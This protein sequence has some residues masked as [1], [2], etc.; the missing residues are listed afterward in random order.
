MEKQQDGTTMTVPVLQLTCDELTSALSI[1]FNKGAYHGQALYRHIMQ[2]GQRDVSAIDAFRNSGDLA[3][4]VQNVLGWATGK[5]TDT[6]HEGE[7]TKFVTTL[8]DGARI[9]SVIIPMRGYSTVCVSSQVGCRQGCVFCETA[10]MG[11]VRQ[12]TAEEIVAQVWRTRHVLGYAVR[13]VVF[14]GMGEPLDNLD[15]VI[16]AIRVMQ[17]QRGLDIPLRRMTLS[18][19]GRVDGLEQLA[20]AGLT[21]IRLAVSLN[22]ANNTLRSRIMPVNRRFPLEALRQALQRFPLP[23]NREF[24]IEY[25]VF[26]G[27]NGSRDHA[28]D[29][30]AFIDDLPVRVNV[31][32]YNPGRHARFEAPDDRELLAFAGYLREQGV[33]TRIRWSK[34][35]SIMA[36][37]G[38]LAAPSE[39]TAA[40][41]TMP[42]PTGSDLSAID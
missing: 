7:T 12:L 36:G 22:A 11:F 6:V 9:E 21:S 30:L 3:D 8:D 18:T 16:Q 19:A 14:M 2:H 38:Q 15:N 24:F 39:T 35:R 10:G 28:R 29:L 5:I 37:C 42:F 26:R 40:P 23:P 27:L 20:H 31:I 33:H 4:K 34:G 41:C 17:D 13:N 1:R 25:V 32:G